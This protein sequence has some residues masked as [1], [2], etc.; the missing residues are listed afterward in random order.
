M[1]PAVASAFFAC[2][3][4]ERDDFDLEEGKSRNDRD[5][6]QNEG[7]DDDYDD[8]ENDG[9]DGA[10]D[11]EPRDEDEIM[12]RIIH[13]VDF[14]QCDDDDTRRTS[15]RGRI[16]RRLSSASATFVSTFST[17]RPS[18]WWSRVKSA[19][20]PNSSPDPNNIPHY[21]L[22]PILS[23]V[24]IPFSILLEIPGLTEHWYIRTGEGGKTVQT[25]RN[26]AILE[27]G[28]VVSFVCAVVANAF[29]VMRFLEYK[30]LAATVACIGF[31]TI[32]G[33]FFI[34]HFWVLK[35]LTLV[36]QILSTSRVSLYSE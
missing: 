19:L 2:R 33:M 22:A 3:L 13:S 21:R 5:E 11:D 20:T 4:S 15:V 23:G 18:A 12:N 36:N 26:T 17:P 28:A 6:D 16:R 30:V 9:E 1:F 35:Y 34:D 14:P 25:K 8:D 31:L 7:Q 24:V 32:H 10:P 27:T 29:L